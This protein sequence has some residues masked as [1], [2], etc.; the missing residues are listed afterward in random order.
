MLG[1]WPQTEII[2]DFWEINLKDDLLYPLLCCL[3]FYSVT[4]SKD[5][6]CLPYRELD[7]YDLLDNAFFFFFFFSLL[8]PFTTHHAVCQSGYALSWIRSS[9]RMKEL[10]WDN[11][12]SAPNSKHCKDPDSF[13]K[14]C[15]KWSAETSVHCK[16][17]HFLTGVTSLLS[18]RH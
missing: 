13:Q 14:C 1:G 6:S 9:E 2:F 3:Q 10:L 7:I 18:L 12:G 4:I 15:C 11:L 5:N 16:P 17:S 8:C